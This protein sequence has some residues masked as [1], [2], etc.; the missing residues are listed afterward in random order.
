VLR[1]W[2]KTLAAEA[3]Y[4]TGVVS[5]LTRRGPRSPLVLAYHRVVESYAASLPRSLPAMLVDVK[6]LEAQ[7]DW[8]ARRYRFASLGEIGSTGEP[9]RRHGRPMACVT[10]DDGYRDVYE[11]AAPLLA[12]KGIPAAIFVVTDLVGST[13]AFAH[14]ALFTLLRRAAGAWGDAREAIGGILRTTGLDPRAVARLT[15]DADDPARLT[16]RLIDALDDDRLRRFRTALGSHLGDDGTALPDQRAVNWPMLESL[17]RAGWTVGSHTASHPLLTHSDPATVER[18]LVESR[19]SLEQ[20]LDT[21]VYA[22]A[23]PG[24]WHDPDVVRAAQRAGYRL[25]FSVCPHLDP[26]R[27]WLTIPRRVFW[28]QTALDARQRF[29]R[30]MM[31]CQVAGV[32]GRSAA[33]PRPG[34]SA[35]PS[36]RLEAS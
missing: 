2:P 32:F 6:T 11:V 22:L 29:S 17:A 28:E 9:Q 12:R 3:L 7:L 21:A 14:D 8:V 36:V 16:P 20:H 25:G 13:R 18:E 5:A 23:Y 24:G 15:R 27:P 19:R 31:A 30:A 4:R 1:Q 33:C 26:E 35:R 10:F 34:M